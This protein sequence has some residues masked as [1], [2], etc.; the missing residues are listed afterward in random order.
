M[1]ESNEAERLGQSFLRDGWPK[2]DA[3]AKAR[4][5][6]VIA[7]QQA[8]EHEAWLKRM[9]SCARELLVLI[10]YRHT[11]GPARQRESIQ[12]VIERMRQ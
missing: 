3:E 6:A 7:A 4:K 1:D 8:S 2:T 10:E 9:R 11:L 12:A 5:A